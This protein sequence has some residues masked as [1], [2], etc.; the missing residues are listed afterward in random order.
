MLDF[1]NTDRAGGG[2]NLH[3]PAHAANGLGAG[4]DVGTDFRVAGNLNRVCNAD[5]AHARVIF[6]DADGIA[7]LF[8]G[9]IRERIV[10]AFLRTLGAEPG[11]TDATVDVNFAVG[12]AGDI[13]VTGGVVEFH[14]DGAGNGVVAIKCAGNRRSALACGDERRGRNES[15]RQIEIAMALHSSS[16]TAQNS[17]PGRPI[18]SYARAGNYVPAAALAER[19]LAVDRVSFRE[20]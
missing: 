3:G 9:R 15:E 6:S 13:H 7:L 19:W 4:S 17:A 11:S 8:D 2:L 16:V 14:T 12:A 18:D 1:F 5:V 20:P 10:E